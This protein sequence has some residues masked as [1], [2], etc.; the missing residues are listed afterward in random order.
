MELSKRNLPSPIEQELGDD[1]MPTG[2]EK[3]AHDDELIGIVRPFDPEKIKIVRET[4][5]V[6]LLNI[7][8]QHGEMDLS[9]D[10]QRNAGIW[11]LKQKSRLIESL[12]LRIPL[13]AFYVASDRDENWAVVDGLQRLSTI[14][15][16]MNGEFSL[17]GLEYL[18][19]LE[20]LSFEK[21]PRSMQRRI[22]ETELVLNVIQPGTPEEVM[23]NVF[24]RINTGG[25][26]LNGQEIRHAINKGPARE[27]LRDL[28]KS[29]EFLQ[30]TSRSISDRRML[31]RECVLRF[32]AFWLTDWREYTSNDLDGFLNSAMR[33]LNEMS[34]WNRSD[35]AAAFQKG[36]RAAFD[37]FGDDAFRKRYDLRDARKPISKPLFET[38]S[39][40]LAKL[41]EAEI[42]YL[43]ENAAVLRGIFSELLLHDRDYEVSI[44]NSTG[45]PARVRRRFIATE[46]MIDKALKKCAK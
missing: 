45:V 9:P 36:M 32:M 23:F 33:K 1:G 38:W 4:K 14:S 20:D 28:A 29:K 25:L 27:L 10:F 11:N 5:T 40:C 42:E 3:E 2:L 15:D 31:A 22:E 19:Q 6:S 12:L 18:V 43:V 26:T 35:C 41:T 17:R 21:L 24:S 34:D 7:R 13:P 8:I 39:V 16:F 37:I 44:S 46:E 30:A